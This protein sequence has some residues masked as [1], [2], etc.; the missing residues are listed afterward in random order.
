[1]DKSTKD[2]MQTLD[3]NETLDQLAMATSVRWH[4]HALRNEKSNS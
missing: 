1:M 3:L 2:L 4:G